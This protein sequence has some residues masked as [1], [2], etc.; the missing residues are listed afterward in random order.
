MSDDLGRVLVVIPTYD[1][2]E[3]IDMIT[4]APPRTTS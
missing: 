1:E 3:N 2:R 4:W